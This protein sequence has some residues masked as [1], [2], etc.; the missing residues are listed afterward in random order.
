[1]NDFQICYKEK[2]LP[3]YKVISLFIDELVE[4]IESVIGTKV[5]YLKKIAKSCKEEAECKQCILINILY[6]E[7]KNNY[8]GNVFKVP[9]EN[10]GGF[11]R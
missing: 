6:D 1:M 5:N 11:R 8:Y 2:K 3:L 9:Q 7:R 4:S 10:S